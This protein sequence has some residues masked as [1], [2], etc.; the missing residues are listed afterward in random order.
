MKVCLA[1]PKST[2][3]TDYTD[4]TDFTDDTKN[5]SGLVPLQP[6]APGGAIGS[7]GKIRKIRIPSPFRPWRRNLNSNRPRESASVRV[8]PRQRF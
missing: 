8:S 3:D 6:L 1:G 4:L 5:H 7:I 2:G